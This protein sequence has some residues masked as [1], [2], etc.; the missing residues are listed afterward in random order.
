MQKWDKSSRTPCAVVIYWLDILNLAKNTFSP[1]CMLTVNQQMLSVLIAS[2]YSRAVTLSAFVLR[3]LLLLA[4]LKR[5][6]PFY[7][8]TEKYTTATLE[9]FFILNLKVSV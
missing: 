1:N 5:I 4:L 7:Q 3:K 8:F 2:S 9:T 6:L